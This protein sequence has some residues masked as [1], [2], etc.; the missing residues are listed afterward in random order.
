MPSLCYAWG[1]KAQG[2]DR[3]I[4][5]AR[6]RID[7]SYTGG[8]GVQILHEV[9]PFLNPSVCQTSILLRVQPGF[10]SLTLVKV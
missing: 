8:G 3:S 6:G 9:A 1:T 2:L 5:K 4:Q 10:G 7:L